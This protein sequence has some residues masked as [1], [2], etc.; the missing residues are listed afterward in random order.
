MKI[1]PKVDEHGFLCAHCSLGK[2]NGSWCDMICRYDCLVGAD[3]YFVLSG[4]ER[5]RNGEAYGL[6]CAQFQEA[7]IC[8]ACGEKVDR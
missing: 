2:W 8:K 4:S 6:H 3:C 7:M 1:I 5:H